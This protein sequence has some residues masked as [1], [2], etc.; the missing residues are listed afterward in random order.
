MNSEPTGFHDRDGIPIHVGDLIRVFHY[1]HRR[2]R[3][4]MW[5]YF[6]VAKK[7]GICVV[8]NWDCLDATKHQC[9]L[10][11]CGLDES[12]VLAESGLNYD[13]RGNLITFNERPRK[14]NVQ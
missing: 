14:R 2:H 8:Q 10:K 1:F 7:D 4:A 5:M 11:Y 6:R 12:E 13:E 9:L 3:K